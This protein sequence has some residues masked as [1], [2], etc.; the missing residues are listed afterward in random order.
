MGK[1]KELDFSGKT[2]YCGLDVHKTNWK[3]NARM[4]GIEVAVFSQNPDPLQLKKYFERNFPGAALKVVYESGF[5]GFE[6]QRS[7][8]ALGV[9]CQVTH[10]ADIPR[11]DK[12]R[13]RKNDKR[14]ARNLSIELSKGHANGI[15]IPDREMEHARAMVRQRH[16]LVRD[17][18]RCIN[19]IKHLLLSKGIAVTGSSGRMSLKLVKKLRESDCGSAVLKAT[20]SYALDQ[21]M[22]LRKI[23]KDITIDIKALSKTEAFSSV[24]TI[25]NSVPGIG[26]INAMIMHTEICEMK[27]FKRLDSL[28]D[29]SG[30]VPDVSSTNDHEV[31]KGMT[32]RANE[33]L[34]EA[35]IES[36]WILIRKDPAMLMK[37]NEYRSRMNSNKAIVR[38][39]KHLLSRIRYLWN[40]NQLYVKG[41]TENSF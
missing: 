28:C 37:F 18:T 31:T 19:R 41:I 23:I 39:A 22:S 12:D 16:R 33:F 29:Y 21:Y 13:K 24:Q 26:L 40:N 38:I 2:I 30:F 6:I 7:L 34:R 4:D 10:A 20:L 5:C 17:Q 9:D 14:D 3:V 15:Y 8:T 36:S 32:S 1:V 11:S 25:L 35:V 27:R